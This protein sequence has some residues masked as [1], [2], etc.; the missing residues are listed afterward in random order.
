MK[1]EVSGVD[2]VKLSQGHSSAVNK[3]CYRTSHFFVNHIKVRITD[4]II[5]QTLVLEHN[6]YH[7]RHLCP[8]SLLNLSST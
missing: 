3:Y 6:H 1:V 4:V 8:L 7:Y 2:V 5:T